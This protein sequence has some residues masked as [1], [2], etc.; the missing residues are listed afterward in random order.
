MAILTKEIDMNILQQVEAQGVTIHSAK[1]EIILLLA[2]IE[3]LAAM[4]PDLGID[5]DEIAE[6]R[7]LLQYPE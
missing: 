5:P 7:H 1:G 3:D 2:R 6:Q 4:H